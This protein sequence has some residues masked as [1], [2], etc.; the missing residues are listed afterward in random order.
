ML[1]SWILYR[2]IMSLSIPRNNFTLQ[3]MKQLCRYE[4][5]ERHLADPEPRNERV[6]STRKCRQRQ[7]HIDGQLCGNKTPNQCRQLWKSLLWQAFYWQTDRCFMHVVH[8]TTYSHV[9]LY[10]RTVFYM[11]VVVIQVD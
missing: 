2:M 3:L 11:V 4:H 5:V 10:C 9:E 7:F 1:N 6:Y 8:S